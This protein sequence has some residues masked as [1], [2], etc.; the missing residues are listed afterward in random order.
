[1]GGILLAAL[2]ALQFELPAGYAG[3]QVV[4][5]YALLG[6]AVALTLA[7]N[8]GRSFVLATSL[9]LAW[10]ICHHLGGKP[11][12]VLV[13]VLMPL[14]ALVAFVTRERGARYGMALRW[15]VLLAA[16]VLLVIWVDAASAPGAKA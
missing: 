3:L 5:P 15:L 9:L 8:R 6:S 16:E 14:N 7:F 11:L 4:G 12:F 2:I 13:T 1:M 10:A